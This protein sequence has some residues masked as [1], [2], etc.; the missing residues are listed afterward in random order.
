MGRFDDRATQPARGPGD[1]FRWRVTD[2][3]AGRR[4][5]ETR[6]Q[7]YA[8]AS[9]ARLALIQSSSTVVDVDRP[10][11]V[12]AASRRQA[13]IVTDPV[14]SRA[15]WRSSRARS[16]PGVALDAMPPID[17]VHRHAR[18]PR[19]HGSRRRLAQLPDSRDVRRAAR[20]RTAGI[21]TQ[22]PNVVELDWWQSHAIGGARDHAR[23][24][25]PLVD[26]HAVESQRHAVGRLRRSRARRRRVSLGRHRV[27][28]RAS[29]RSASA[30]GRSTGRCCRSARTSRA[31]SWSRS[32]WIRKTPAT[33][34]AAAARA[35]CSRCTGARSSS[36]TSRSASRRSASRKYFREHGMPASDCGSS[37]SARRA[38]F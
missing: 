31:G 23:A 22:A 12:R 4:V 25:A 30:A 1:I 13:R 26:A 16:P 5:K 21:R 2:A 34:S 27:L 7:L 24:G 15:S 10:R 18:S 37:T 9:R 17:I 19:S 6:S 33:P 20:Q 3:L 35:I 29:P 38:R 32:T 14:W 8:A 36:P 11:D 28:R